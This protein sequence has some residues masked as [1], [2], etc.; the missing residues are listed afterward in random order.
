VQPAALFKSAAQARE[1]AAISTANIEE[2]QE[3]LRFED[4]LIKH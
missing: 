1:D 4:A 2:T 3:V